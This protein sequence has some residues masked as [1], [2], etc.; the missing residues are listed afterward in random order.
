[1]SRTPTAR[2]RTGRAG[3]A[4]AVAYALACGW[5]VLETNV[6]TPSGEIDLIVRDQTELALIEV[7]ARRTESFGTGVESLTPRK[8]SRMAACA[9]EYLVARGLH[10]DTT[11]WRVDLIAVT[12]TPG[13]EPGVEHLPHVLAD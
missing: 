1:M 3:E 9:F 8:R 10:P 2:Q 5:E 12:L 7:R 11:A 4:I 6:R 13:K